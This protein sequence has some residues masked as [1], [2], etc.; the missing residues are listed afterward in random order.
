M[1][2]FRSDA[3]KTVAD[4][5]SSE[6]VINLGEDIDFLKEYEDH[7]ADYKIKS[8]Y[9]NSKGISNTL[10]KK[11]CQYRIEQ[12]IEGYR[13]YCRQLAA[14]QVDQQVQLSDFT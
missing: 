7:D 4:P 5:E 6:N 1:I 14:E 11:W 2:V 3:E 12:T 8:R 13:E 9:T 10:E